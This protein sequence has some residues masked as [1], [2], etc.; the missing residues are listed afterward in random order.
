[1][2]KVEHYFRVPFGNIILVSSLVFSLVVQIG[3]QRKELD[4]L[5]I[6]IEKP[7]SDSVACDII[8]WT[9]GYFW[10]YDLDSAMLLLDRSMEM[11]R[12]VNHREIIY[13]NYYRYA[14]TYYY[15]G[16]IDSALISID[17][18]LE[19]MEGFDNIKF[20]AG[21]LNIK[22]VIYD[23][24]GD[25]QRSIDANLEA[26]KLFE[27]INDSLNLYAQYNNIAK[28]YIHIMD[29]ENGRKY[30]QMAID[31]L[32]ETKDSVTLA[33]SLIT[34]SNVDQGDTLSLFKDEIDEA[35]LIG[36]KLNSTSILG[37]ANLSKGSLYYR[38][39][40]FEQALPF[41]EEAL[42]NNKK[43]GHGTQYLTSMRIVGQIR[44]TLGEREL[45]ERLLKGTLQE[46]IEYS[47]Y[48]NIEATKMEL[49]FHYNRY[50][51]HKEANKYLLE[52]TELKDSTYHEELALQ[53]QNAREKFQTEQK[54]KQIVEQQLEIARQSHARNQVLYGGLLALLLASGI[55]TWYY[56]RQKRKKQE[57]ELA[58]KLEKAEAE[59]LRHLDEL[60][61]NFFTNLSHE[62]RTPLTLILGPLKKAQEST[63]EEATRKEIELAHRNASKLHSLVNEIMDLSKLEAGKLKME[64]HKMPFEA[65][66]RRIFYSFESLAGMRNIDLTWENQLR[67]NYLIHIDQKRFE[68]VINNLVSNAVKFSPDRSRVSLTVEERGN[69][70]LIKVQDQGMGIAKEDLPHV[71]DRFF[72]TKRNNAPLE[73]GTGIGLAYAKE[74]VQRF[75]GDITAESELGQGSTFTV[76]L[77]LALFE[78]FDGVSQLATPPKESQKVKTYNPIT[79]GGEKPRILVVE[80]H[81]EMSAYIKTLLE[82]D[83]R[84][85]TALDGK[86]GLEKMMKE[87][88]D[89][90]TTDIMMPNMDGFEL[91]EEVLKNESK[92]QIP[93]VMLTARAMEEDKLRGLRL[94]VDDYLTKPFSAE[95]LQARIKNLLQN[96][97]EREE[98]E[99]NPQEEHEALNADQ[100]VMKRAE[101]FVLEHLDDVKLSVPELSKA[102]GYSQRQITRIIKRIS[103]LTP[104]NFI[105]EM[106]LQRGRQLIEQKKYSSI[107]QVRYEVGIESASYFSRKFKERF[108]KSPSEF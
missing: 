53:A 22:S 13:K 78:V 86:E 56:Q 24:V 91:R 34:L 20:Q 43:A 18:G 25:Y 90:V 77:P 30:A 31:G 92:R 61:S 66:M 68:K 47:N 10:A 67:N 42:A 52:Y 64:R 101:E 100:Q 23:G 8:G 51:Q 7:M 58:L 17:R 108:G 1:M 12:K 71:F 62:L 104:V 9:A 21:F 54:E 26:A 55:F 14:T 59:N 93:F 80:D 89:L 102:L 46:A 57:A 106:R 87:Q 74:I 16:E 4:S 38:K 29:Y 70:V 79:I 85:E 41:Y 32:R 99:N 63:K 72:Q 33:I 50:N 84:V 5:L 105:L 49:F 39:G 76:H 44:S 103:G 82:Q 88:F 40:Q 45:G 81:P 107:D 28:V 83:Y 96:K 15:L 2:I 69:Q 98:S 36:R 97:I 3:A 6:E 37:L 60:K 48:E 94:G 95:E 11:C 35:L 19:A 27:S 75:D 65:L 73:G